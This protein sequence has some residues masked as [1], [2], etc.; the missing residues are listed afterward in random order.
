MS[1]PLTDLKCVCD[2]FI[3]CGKIESK[4][5]LQYVLTIVVLS[6]LWRKMNSN[7]IFFVMLTICMRPKKFLDNFIYI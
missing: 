7:G 3:S 4:C 1:N 2:H 5:E 6:F